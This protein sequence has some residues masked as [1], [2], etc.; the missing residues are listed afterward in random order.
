MTAKRISVTMT[1][2]EAEALR[3]LLDAAHA[4]NKSDLVKHAAGYTDEHGQPCLYCEEKRQRIVLWAEEFDC[5]EAAER[6]RTTLRT[7]L[8]TWPADGREG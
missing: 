8:R 3:Q 7:T 2:H 6:L 5:G 4:W 1:R